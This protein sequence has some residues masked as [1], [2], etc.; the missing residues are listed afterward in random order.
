MKPRV[1]AR[2]IADIPLEV[3]AGLNA[4]ELETG[5]LVEGLA[6]DFQTLL[7]TAFPTV[8]HRLAIDRALPYTQRLRLSAELIAHHVPLESVLT[9]RS[10]TIRGIGGYIIG[11]NPQL[12]VAQVVEAIRPLAADPHFGVREWAWLGIR[13]RIVAQPAE[14][15]SAFVPWSLEDDSNI[16]RFGCEAT[17]PRGV[18][19]AHIRELREEPWLAL[20]VLAPLCADPSKYVQ[21]SVANW[22]NDASKTQPVW[23]R[24]LTQKWLAESDCDST[25]KIVKRA[26]RTLDAQK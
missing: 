3:L 17:R 10:D 25:K 9:H 6:I 22:L 1:A 18:W 2:R 8:A 24:E 26:L 5:N 21:D 4:G 13:P 7:Q 20:S 12:S 11:M 15:I 23:V 19:C 14:F 16:R